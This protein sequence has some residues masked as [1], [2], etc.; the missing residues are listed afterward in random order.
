MAASFWEFVA[1]NRSKKIANEYLGGWLSSDPEPAA[2]PAG[3]Q[4]ERLLQ[5]TQPMV[6][7]ITIAR[8]SLEF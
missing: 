1:G 3:R 6:L 5:F 8:K 7:E 4:G 2:A